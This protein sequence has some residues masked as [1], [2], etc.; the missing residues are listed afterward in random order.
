MI[1]QAYQFQYLV[2]LKNIHNTDPFDPFINYLTLKRFQLQL[3]ADII[4]TSF[5]NISK[6]FELLATSDLLVIIFRIVQ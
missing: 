2:D 3:I 1:F 5:D 6:W 4:H